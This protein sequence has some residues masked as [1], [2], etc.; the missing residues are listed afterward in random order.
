MLWRAKLNP[1]RERKTV[2][3]TAALMCG[4]ES[5]RYQR[6]N[7]SYRDSAWHCANQK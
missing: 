5:L 7:E 3:R 4:G 2:L 1:E 6:P